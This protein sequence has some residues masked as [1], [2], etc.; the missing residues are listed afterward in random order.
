MQMRNLRRSYP[1]LLMGC[2]AL[3]LSTVRASPILA[4]VQD[5]DKL[6]QIRQEE[7]QDYFAKW[8]KSDVRFIIMPEEKDVFLS[9]TTPEEKERFIE[10]FWF[11]RDPDPSTA[12]NEFKEEHYRRI[13]F[14]N[15]R[16][17]EGTPGWLTDRGR[18]YIIHGE[19]DQ[20]E[21]HV[22][23]EAWYD[24]LPEEGGGSTSTF[25][26]I[27]WWYRHIN[28]IGDNV[29][30]EFVDKRFTGAYQLALTPW[31]KDAL[32]HTEWGHTWAEEAGVAERV[33]RYRYPGRAGLSDKFT[34][35][36]AQDNPF[37]KYRRHIMM[38]APQPVKYKDFEKL[39]DVNITYEVLP[40]K[41]R[42]DYLRLDE[43]HVLVPITVQLQNQ[44]LDF[45]QEGTVHVARMGIYGRIISLSN[46]L[47]M[48]FED[49]LMIAYRPELLQKG[50]TERSMYQ[51]ILTLEKRGRY[52]LDLVVKDLRSGKVG[53]LQQAIIPPPYGEDKLA[54]SSL[55][56]SGYI[57][58]LDS[59]PE[60]DQMFVLGDVRIRP[61]MMKLFNQDRS[62]GVYLQLYNSAIDQTTFQPSL[63]VSYRILKD[64]QPVM[65]V[66]DEGGESV[67]YY[68]GRRVVLIK[69]LPLRG[70][71]R[72]EYS[73]QIEVHDQISNQQVTTKDEFRVVDN[74]QAA[75]KRR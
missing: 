14:A 11:R 75:L 59:A 61:S 62:L 15:E 52:K 3:M 68:S 20:I 37:E 17:A 54:S 50:L 1:M 64:G 47:V 67:Q 55:I 44:Y 26:F 16:F 23:G 29:E 25:P 7:E 31:E 27:R 70:L 12:Y 34:A 33:D 48:E 60:Q 8:L 49:D 30:L 21:S 57:R 40:L 38:E 4:A 51:K 9:L 43:G 5:K 19:P 46:R 39:V 41:V 32:M 65:E 24:R 53:V 22:A 72:G 10:Q 35:Y 13:A 66:V 63:K 58:T 56:L 71:E 36:R 73:L 42:L 74:V 45:V 2:V 69:V 6:E 18:I 28:G